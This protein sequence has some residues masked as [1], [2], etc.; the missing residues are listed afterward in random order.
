MSLVIVTYVPEG[1]V[2]ASDS[3]QSLNMEKKSKDGSLP[4]RTNI[5]NSD[6]VH[7]TFVLKNHKI[8]INT[9]GQDLIKGVPTSSYIKQFEETLSEKDSI[10]TVPKKILK[11]F[12]SIDQNANIGF[13]L[14]GYAKEIKEELTKSAKKEIS[15]PHVYFLNIKQGKIVRKN[16]DDSQKCVLY[17]A[18]WGGESDIIAGLLKIGDKD[19]PQIVWGAMALQD[20]IDFSI[21]SISTTASTMRFL[22]RPKTVGGPIDV[23]IITPE[24]T[25]WIQKKE[26]HGAIK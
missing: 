17:G 1:L 26:F 12:G 23:L 6:S 16:Y 4:E 15:T 2:L 13:H 24:G 14:A 21:F 22:A 5:V 18:T 19:V 7:K 8:G 9:F 3:R 10:R 11:F 20:A 25:K